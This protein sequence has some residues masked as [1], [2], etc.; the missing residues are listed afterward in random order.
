MTK[1][2]AVAMARNNTRKIEEAFGVKFLR[3]GLC[4]V[5]HTSKTGKHRRNTLSRPQRRKTQNPLQ[6]RKVRKT[7]IRK[8]SSRYRTS[9]NL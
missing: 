3:S 7:A 6:R 5:R 8:S 4:I 9:G 2:E 1:I